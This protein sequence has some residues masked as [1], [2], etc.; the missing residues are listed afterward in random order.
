M[1]RELEI[2]SRAVQP[3]LGT[4]GDNSGP[5]TELGDAATTV[6]LPAETCVMDFLGFVL[7]GRSRRSIGH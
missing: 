5:P 6:P 2:E 7:L 3:S 1:Q 4:S